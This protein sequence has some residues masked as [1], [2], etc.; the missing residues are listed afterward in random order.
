[1]V[2]NGAGSFEGKVET[3]SLEVLPGW[4]GARVYILRLPE[5]LTMALKGQKQRSMSLPRKE[6]E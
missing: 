6:R 1:M 3:A 4:A 2:G 5:E